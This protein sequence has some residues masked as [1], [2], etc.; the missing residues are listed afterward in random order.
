MTRKEFINLLIKELGEYYYRSSL[1]T[2]CAD[3]GVDIKKDR[4]AKERYQGLGFVT[5]GLTT[6]GE[7]DIVKILGMNNRAN[8][9]TG[10]ALNIESIDIAITLVESLMSFADLE[11]VKGHGEYNRQMAVLHTMLEDVLYR[12]EHT[13]REYTHYL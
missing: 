10:Q 4:S 3:L 7:N 8:I 11:R 2:F 12:L 1:E 5:R 6:L 13:E 9:S